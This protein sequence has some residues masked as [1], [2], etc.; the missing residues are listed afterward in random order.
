MHLINS[1]V[2][3]C[4]RLKGSETQ[5]EFFRSDTEVKDTMAEPDGL[6]AHV[7]DTAHQQRARDESR[8]PP[9]QLRSKPSSQATFFFVLM[10]LIL[11]PE[12]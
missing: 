3:V 9:Q 7:C 4:V 2:F 10:V 8:E 11:W 6:A 12:L 1:L 5:L